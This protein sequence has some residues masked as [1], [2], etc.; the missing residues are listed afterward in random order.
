MGRIRGQR[1]DCDQPFAGAFG[2]A[3]RQRRAKLGEGADQGEVLTTQGAP[4]DRPG[5]LPAGRRGEPGIA[6]L[7]RAPAAAQRH[8][9]GG[10]ATPSQHAR[11]VERARGRDR[12][13]FAVVQRGGEQP[14]QMVQR[15]RPR[16]GDEVELQ[17]GCCGI[18]AGP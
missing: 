17:V 6:D 14:L 12:E 8:G 13:G 11:V 16:V 9:L 1:P 18:E 3:R 4:G 2:Q 10:H 15:D 5:R 7:E